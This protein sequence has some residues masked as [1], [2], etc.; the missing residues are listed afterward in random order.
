MG[1]KP[2]HRQRSI[3]ATMGVVDLEQVS[4]RL[5]SGRE[6]DVGLR[7]FVSDNAIHY[8]A[9]RTSRPSNLVEKHNVIQLRR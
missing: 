6:A 5:Q 1:P 4:A 2:I 7:K 8:V 3:R 9:S